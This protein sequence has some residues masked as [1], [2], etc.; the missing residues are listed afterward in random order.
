M[1]GMH[2]MHRLLRI[3][4]ICLLATACGGPEAVDGEVEEYVDAGHIRF[5]Y[6]PDRP[7]CA[8]TPKFLDDMLSRLGDYLGLPLPERVEFH[9]HPDPDLSQVCGTEVSYAGCSYPGEKRVWE[10]DATSVHEIVHAL[11]DQDGEHYSFLAEGL[12]TALGDQNVWLTDYNAD[13]ATYLTSGS[14]SPAKN[15]GLAGDLVSYLLVEFGAKRFMDLYARV[16]PRATSQGFKDE[17]NAVYG[18][19]FDEV[20]AQRRV[21]TSRFAQNRLRFPEC[22]LPVVDWDADLWSAT[23]DVDCAT[24]GIGPSTR[25]SGRAG[26][27]WLGQ[28]LEIAEEASS[29]S[30]FR[31]APGAP[32]STIANPRTRAGRSPIPGSRSRRAQADGHSRT[33]GSRQG[34]MRC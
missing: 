21:A 13:E 30:P 32:T 20:L 5:Y 18:L 9:Y 1:H 16:S 4:G 19:D 3:G 12:A 10:R 31:V 23:N 11:A 26:T 33:G 22:S 6:P 34:A 17:F 15:G 29:N 28:N 14:F 27:A 25:L 7:V 24:S 2:G 8:G